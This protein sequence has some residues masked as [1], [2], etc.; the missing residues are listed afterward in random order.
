MKIFTNEELVAKKKKQAGILTPIAMVALLGGLAT[1]FLSIRGDKTDLTYLTITITLLGIG[2]V[3]ATISAHLVNHWVKEPRP[4]QILAQLLKGFDGKHFLF[5]HTTAVPHI[6]ITQNKVYA[7][8]PK[9]IDGEISVEQRR[10]RRKFKFSRFLKF[11]GDE[12]LGNPTLDAAQQR[13]RLIKLIEQHIPD[14][15]GIPVEALI[16][17]TN[18]ATT[19]TVKDSPIPVMAGSQLKK[20]L[21]QETKGPALNAEVRKELVQ[22]FNN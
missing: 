6:L 17:F 3:A 21:R 16:V 5:N 20:F 22:I 1:N 18:P 9:I 8:S 2:F 14:S 10:W 13:A 19:L 15:D 7:I 12:G 4:D 11:F